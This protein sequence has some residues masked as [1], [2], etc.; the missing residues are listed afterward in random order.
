LAGK[1]YLITLHIHFTNNL[2]PPLPAAVL[3]FSPLSP[4]QVGPSELTEVEI[5]FEGKKQVWKS[6][7][8]IKKCRYLENSGCTGMCINMCKVPTQK[9]FT[10]TFGLP[11]TM[12]PD[13]ETLECEM[14]FGQEPPPIEQDD[15]YN[16]PCLSVCNLARLSDT[17]GGGNKAPPACPKTDTDRTAAMAKK[18]NAAAASSSSSATS[19]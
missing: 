9:F 11:L 17:V 19:A 8:K 15:V 5:E 7:V 6:G 18:L 13:F 16:Q 1:N 10:D 3:P 14:I 4:T 12:N 2:Q